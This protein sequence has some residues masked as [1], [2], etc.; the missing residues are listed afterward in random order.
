MKK[1]KKQKQVYID[2]GH[3][4]Y[5]MEQ[6]VGPENYDK[7]EKRAG[8][9]KKERRAAISAAFEVYLPV[10]V[11]VLACFSL[12]AVLIYFWLR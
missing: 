4:I 2:D 12:V 7:K 11:G 10:L 5:S 1:E 3:T 8:L 6:L 9:T